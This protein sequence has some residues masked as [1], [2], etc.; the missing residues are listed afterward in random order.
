[1]DT[2]PHFDLDLIQIR[3]RHLQKINAD[4]QHC[5]QGNPITGVGY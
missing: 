2:V 4:P 5:E 3:I 1:M